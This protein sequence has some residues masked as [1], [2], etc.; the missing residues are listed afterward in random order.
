MA[1]AVSPSRCIVTAIM[2]CAAFSLAAQDLSE[3]AQ[4]ALA[5]CEDAYRAC[6]KACLGS[7]CDTCESIRNACRAEV[8]AN[9]GGTAGRS[10]AGWRMAG[11]RLV[12]LPYIPGISRPKAPRPYPG[13]GTPSDPP[14]NPQGDRGQL[15]QRCD[16]GQYDAV[17]QR[18]RSSNGGGPSADSVLARI[19]QEQETLDA[20]I[21]DLEATSN[22]QDAKRAERKEAKEKLERA[23][24]QL[25]V[26]QGA[27]KLIEG[28]PDISDATRRASV[29][30]GIHETLNRILKDGIRARSDVAGHVVGENGTEQDIVDSP[31]T[32]YG[33][34]QNA[35]ANIFSQYGNG[36][37][38]TVEELLELCET[39][40]RDSVIAGC[41]AE[42]L[43]R[44]GASPIDASG[45]CQ[46]E[47]FNNAVQCCTE[48]GI[49][50]RD[51]R[52]RFTITRC[53]PDRRSPK[54]NHQSRRNGCGT[55]ALIGATGDNLDNMNWRYERDGWSIRRVYF[56]PSFLP[57]CDFHDDCWGTCNTSET[58]TSQEA[59]DAEFGNRLLQICAASLTGQNLE[60]CQW[61]ARKYQ[62]AVSSHSMMTYNASQ[63]AACDCCEVGG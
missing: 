41:R 47:P 43:K 53:P 14:P 20:S 28:L 6:A 57:A 33:D 4:N 22:D 7:T 30:A 12:F 10:P 59:C 27:K 8:Y 46:G 62:G 5:K 16:P 2:L 29:V 51:D 38:M 9:V 13:D 54:P 35:L 56:G 25:A 17:L 18:Y 58:G 21:R 26:L 48:G 49:G 60:D 15:A 36:Q 63:A 1:H 37:E 24:Q 55:D 31:H 34:K 23:R 61:R 39:T 45:E 52:T 44:A 3:S 42:P 19:E 40:G 50:T 32:S 11:S